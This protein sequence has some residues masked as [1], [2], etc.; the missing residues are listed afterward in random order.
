MWHYTCFISTW[1]IHCLYSC[2][3]AIY[4][5]PKDASARGHSF[6][7]N[8]G[9][10][11]WARETLKIFCKVFLAHVTALW[12]STARYTCWSMLLLTVMNSSFYWNEICPIQK[13]IYIPL[14]VFH[15]NIDAPPPPLHA[16]APTLFGR[17]VENH[18]S[19]HTPEIRQRNSCKLRHRY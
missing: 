14:C 19:C 1:D 6:Y 18:T 10:L 13:W 4:T 2:V 7:V 3:S 12:D 17:N 11:S 15:L 9:I 16:C 8:K 5:T